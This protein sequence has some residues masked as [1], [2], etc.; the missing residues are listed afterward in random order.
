MVATPIGNMD[1]ITIRAVKILASVDFIAAE[2]TRHTRKLLHYHHIQTRLISCHEHN[3]DQRTPELI[4][5]LRS[6][7]SIALVSDA[8]T[9]TISDPGYRLVCEAVKQDIDIV[10]IPGPSAAI[11]ALSASGLAT[12]A[13]LFVGFPPAKTNRRIEK[14]QSISDIQATLVFYESPKR[15]LQFLDELLQCIGNRYMVLGREITK[16][17]EEFIRGDTSGIIEKMK[18]RPAIKGECV[19]LVE[20]APKTETSWTAVEHE[21][22]KALEKG[23]KKISGL[24]KQIASKY[25]VSKKQV[26]EALL[27]KSGKKHT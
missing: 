23:G 3:E 22:D 25:G 20:G 10:P 13:F 4:D 7:Q 8:G 17:H 1:D 21:I 11:A 14:L 27:E 5:K 12:D 16:I 15:I 24:S 18:M 26:Y 2:D 6:G 9:P 19:I